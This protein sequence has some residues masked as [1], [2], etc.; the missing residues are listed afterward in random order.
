MECVA[1]EARPCKRPSISTAIDLGKL[2]DDGLGGD[3][4]FRLHL[5]NQ[6]PP[7]SSPRRPQRADAAFPH[8]GAERISSR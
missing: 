4:G 5:V 2:F 1:F 6:P 7:V 8:R 3:F